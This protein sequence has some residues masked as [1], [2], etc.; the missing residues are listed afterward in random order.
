MSVE[1]PR[2]C[3][4]IMENGTEV[5]FDVRYLGPDEWF[6]TPVIAAWEPMIEGDYVDLLP[7]VIGMKADR[8][9]HDNVLSF[10][11]RF[12]PDDPQG[13]SNRFLQNSDCLTDS[14]ERAEGHARW[15]V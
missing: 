12:Y 11:P 15:R 9:P 5:P 10:S 7:K 14:R 8:W 3:R 4:F 13:W 6:G 1:K 2:G